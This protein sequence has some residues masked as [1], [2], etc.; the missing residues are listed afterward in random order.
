MVEVHIGIGSNI[1]PELNFSL[2]YDSLRKVFSNIEFSRTFK[3]AAIGFIGDDFYNSVAKFSI[4][5]QNQNSLNLLANTQQEL[6]AIERQLG[7]TKEG[8][9]FSARVI[10]I[11][12]LL[13]GDLVCDEPI[14][15]PRGEILENAY[16]LWP[17]S[18]LSPKLLHPIAK[19]SYGA[20]WRCF[21]KQSQQLVAI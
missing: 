21:D 4:A 16:V 5:N 18:E 9:K 2:A 10:D 14:E 1:D 3:S 19:Q 15:L 13:F 7:R 17:I 6:K 20:L 12:I 8:E 11:D